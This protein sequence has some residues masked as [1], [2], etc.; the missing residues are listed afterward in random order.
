MSFSDYAEAAILDHVFGKSAMAQPQTY[1]GLTTEDPGEAGAVTEPSGGDYARVE[2][3]P[4]GWVRSGNTVTTSAT[5]SFPE[6]TAPWGTVT[7]FVICDAPTGG[8][9]LMYAPLDEP[10]AV[11][12]NDI[13]RF[14]DGSITITLD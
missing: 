1:L 3:L 4:S 6:A 9:V 13:L 14:V 8:N 7:H 2:V 12:E 10:K 5:V 11:S